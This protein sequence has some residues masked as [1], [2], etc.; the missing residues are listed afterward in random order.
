MKKVYTVIWSESGK[1]A[2]PADSEHS[3]FWTAKEEAEKYAK[4]CNDNMSFLRRLVGGGHSY[5]VKTL[6]AAKVNKVIT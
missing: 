3:V 2:L 4:R 6:E 1:V 5:C